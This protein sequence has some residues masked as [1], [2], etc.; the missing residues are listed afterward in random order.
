MKKNLLFILFCFLTTYFY[1][2]D[3]LFITKTTNYLDS[4]S[5][6]D[7]V[8]SSNLKSFF[9]QGCEKKVNIEY[10]APDT[11]IA[12]AE[13][14]L[15]IPHCMGGTSMSCIDCSGLLFAVFS[16]L[17]VEIP[18]GSESVA[19]YGRL[20]LDK[21]SLQKGDLVFFVKSYRTSKLITHSGFYIGNGMMIHASARNGVEEINIW[22]SNYWNSKFVFGTRL[23]ENQNI[24][25]K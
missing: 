8:L 16:E 23:F 9:N 15:G 2:Q 4:I 25:A 17:Q 13:K 14:Y 10:V 20:I 22:N 5:K 12:K 21:D 3:T 18:H 1:G 19:H 6:K 7:A 24:E 11:L